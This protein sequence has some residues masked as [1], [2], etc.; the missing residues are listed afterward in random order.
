MSNAID[1]SVIEIRLSLRGR[2]IGETLLGRTSVT[3][4]RAA[5]DAAESRCNYGRLAASAVVV[6][7]EVRKG[8]YGS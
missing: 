1:S 7:R 8:V 5:F 6:A 2:S 4:A 3:R